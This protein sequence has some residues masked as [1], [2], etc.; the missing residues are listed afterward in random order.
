MY[1]FLFLLINCGTVQLWY[2]CGGRSRKKRLRLKGWTVAAKSGGT[3][4]FADTGQAFASLPASG[5]RVADKEP[6]GR[7]RWTAHVEVEGWRVFLLFPA[8][9]M[10]A[11]SA[12]HEATAL[13]ARAKRRQIKQHQPKPA[14]TRRRA[15]HGSR[16][17]FSFCLEA[18][19]AR[20][21]KTMEAAMR[22][23]KER[24]RH[25]KLERSGTRRADGSFLYLKN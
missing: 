4:R 10:T 20:A 13:I 18:R 23:R 3:E 2:W 25:D 11:R 15:K 7:G 19:K 17:I 21:K 12:L 1:S 16:W 24:K 9:T 5:A 22:K 14:A 8:K 6:E